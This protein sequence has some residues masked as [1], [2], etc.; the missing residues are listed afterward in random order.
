MVGVDRAEPAHR[1]RHWNLQA[2]GKLEQFR[3]RAAVADRLPD[4]ND[5]ALGAEQHVDGFHD[6]FGIGAA[7][8]RDVAVPVLRVRRFFGGRFHEHIVGHVQ[9]HRA[10]PSRHHRLPRLPYRER[11]HVAARRLEHPFAQAAHGRGEVGLVLPVHFLEGAAVELAGRHVA[12]DGQER[13]RVEI[14]GGQRNRQLRRTGTARG[15]GRG[16][17]TRH[18]VIDVGHEAGDAFVMHRDRLD[19]RR[20]LV[21]RVD[22]LDIA[23]AAQAE[24]LRHFLLDQIVDDDLRAVELV[25]SSPSI[26]LPLASIAV[27]SR[28]RKLGLIML[29][30]N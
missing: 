14:G 11:H 19:V 12:G 24:H 30:V 22:E 26:P 28:A 3:G 8:A 25:A 1:C 6:A 23:V 18:A 2:L 7:T 5:R 29:Y 10:R 9:H 20:A 16:R 17:L 13:H 27:S 15:K 4:K 21:Q